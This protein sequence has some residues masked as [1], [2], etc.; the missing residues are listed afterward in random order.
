MRTEGITFI[1]PAYNVEKYIGQCLESL[2]QQTCDKYKVIIVDDGSKDKTADICKQYVKK[3]PEKFSYIWQKNQGQGAARNNGLRQKI[4]TIYT[5]FLDSDDWL[6][7]R[8]VETVLEQLNRYDDDGI[9]MVFTLPIMYNDLTG[10]TMDWLDKP[11]FD[12]IFT[13]TTRV[14]ETITDNR[15]YGLEVNVCRRVYRTDF[16]ERIDFKFP[17]G[18]KWED[19]F[20]HFFLLT[21]ARKVLGIPEVGFYY[22]TNVPT[23]TT[24]TSGKDRLNIVPVFKQT[25]NYLIDGEYNDEIMN[26]AM[27]DMVIFSTWSLSVSKCEIRKELVKQ[28][29]ELYV[30]IP[31]D[32]VKK[33]LNVYKHWSRK[34]T[35]FFRILRSKRWHGLLSDYVPVGIGTAILSK[36]VKGV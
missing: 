28:L 16:L 27:N 9:E 5:S 15:L 34:N 26:F 21:N 17:E 19:V 8:F 31:D 32:V 30:T 10:Q 13:E 25:I 12:Q 24:S 33:Y 29:H 2:V 23:S 7:V 3:Y 6:N 14:V 36:F 11:L 35:I 4:D 22:R 20:P 18:V 1:I